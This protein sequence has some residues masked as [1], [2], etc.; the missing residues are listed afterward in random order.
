MLRVRA[1]K[2]DG[3]LLGVKA[4]VILDPSS[5]RAIVSLKGLPVGGSI[6]GVAKF[7]QDGQSVEVDDDMDRA[8]SRRGVSI[9]NA[10]AYNDY[11]YVWVRIKLPMGLGTHRMILP[12][13]ST[14]TGGHAL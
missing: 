1:M 5:E 10:G 9:V 13:T 14:K 6:N 7:K 12:R 8:L 4:S 11:S 2:Y 3:K